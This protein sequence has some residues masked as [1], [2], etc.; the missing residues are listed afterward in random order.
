MLQYSPPKAKLWGHQVSRHTA[1][2]VL[3]LCQQFVNQYCDIKPPP[4]FPVEP[5]RLLLVWPKSSEAQVASLVAELQALLGAPFESNDIPLGPPMRMQTW[6]H[7]EVQ[8]PVI[9]ELYNRHATMFNKGKVNFVATGGWFFTWRD[10]SSPDPLGGHLACHITSPLTV[11]THFAFRDFKHY[12][13]IK[14]HFQQ[15]G[16]LEMSEKHLTPKALVKAYLAGKE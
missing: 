5:D 3:K 8:L 9:A 2:D 12:E 16:L 1:T 10:D 6:Q 11:G 4:P 13:V 14:Q 7:R 15:V